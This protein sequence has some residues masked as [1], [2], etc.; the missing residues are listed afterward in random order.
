MIAAVLGAGTGSVS[1]VE[2]I[3]STSI[4]GMAA[5]NVIDVQAS[6]VDLDEAVAVLE[7]PL[8]AMGFERLPYDHDH[9]PAARFVQ[10]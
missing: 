8:T 6:V 7:G 5:K 2:H 1:R 10:C 4:P 9:V 3:G